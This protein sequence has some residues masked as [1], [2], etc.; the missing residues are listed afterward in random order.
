MVT[1][2]QTFVRS[3]VGKKACMA[4]SGLLLVGFLVAHL[5]GNLTLFLPD[6]G[7]AFDAYAQKL[8]DLGPLLYVAEVGLLALFVVHIAFAAWTTIGNRK[9]RTS[10]YAV[11][12]DHGERT[13]ASS[14]M[15]ITGLIVL[16]FLIVHLIHF[17]LD[18]RFEQGPFDLVEGTLAGPIAALIYIV[19]VLALT[20]HLTHAIGSALQTLGVNHPRWSPL[21]RRAGVGLALILG[22]GFLS[23]PIY[24]LIAWGGSN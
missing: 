21:L 18:E 8:H 1:W 19:G 15:P 20:L 17:R 10:R 3:S 14:T 23:I 13:V 16:L 24:A 9:A 22:L 4:I 5:A 12:P 11:Q 2:L 6:D 7:A